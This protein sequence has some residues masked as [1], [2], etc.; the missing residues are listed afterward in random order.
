MLPQAVPMAPVV[1]ILVRRI[2]FASLLNAGM[3]VLIK[4]WNLRRLKAP[5]STVK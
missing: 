5:M 3:G 1:M 4:A 2:T